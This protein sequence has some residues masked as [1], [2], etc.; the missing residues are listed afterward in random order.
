MKIRTSAVHRFL[1]IEPRQYQLA[2]VDREALQDLPI[3][4]EVYFG[5]F[6]YQGIYGKSILLGDSV[7]VG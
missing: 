5:D 7:Y 6:C 3:S 4:S 2:E 1:S